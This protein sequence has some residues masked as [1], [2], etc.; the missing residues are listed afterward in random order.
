M[1]QA[2]RV[3][4]KKIISYCDDITEMAA[5]LGQSYEAFAQQTAYQYAV[6]MCILQIGKLVSRLSDEGIA[7]IP[8]V[9]WREIRGDAQYLCPQL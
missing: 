7:S 9:P 4:L 2:D 1:K 6:G 8:D 3:V 5:Q